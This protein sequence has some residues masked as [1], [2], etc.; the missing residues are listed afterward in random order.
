V[1]GVR[2]RD[3]VALHCISS[4]QV[5]LRVDLAV[6]ARVADTWFDAK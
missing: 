2:E 3:M 1:S 5:K 6:D 4:M